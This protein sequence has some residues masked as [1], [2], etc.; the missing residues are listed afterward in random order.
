VAIKGK[1]KRS[2]GRPMRRPATAPRPQV[3]ERR[4][5]WYR[6]TAFVVT[7][8]VVVLA[9]T[10]LAAWNRVQLGWGRD[11]VRRFSTQ[12]RTQTDQLTAILG[13]GT[14]QL[15]G[16][17]TAA[18]V[19]S[20][21]LKPKDLQVRASGWSAK[22]D[23]LSQ[24]VA[25][26]TV[27][28]PEAVS[29]F[30]GTPVNSV[31]GHVPLLTSVRDAYTAAFGF[32]GQAATTYQAAGGASGATMQQL[33]QQAQGESAKAG[34]A[35]DNAA[36]LLAR[37]MVQYDLPV[38]QQLPGESSTAFGNRTGAVSSDPSRQIDPTQVPGTD[39]SGTPI[40]PTSGATAPPS[41]AGNP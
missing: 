19:A 12:L 31:G 3:V 8:A 2:Q 20:G 36:A 27:G 38:G 1:T 22:I 28:S 39:Q 30:D 29:S 10:L 15:P 11:D 26:L 35:M 14:K 40:P 4:A 17:S 6:A 25:N 9:V 32:Y 13:A 21:S 16:M 5:P 18:D 24:K 23:E 34:Q 37:V 7:I 41:T 33:L